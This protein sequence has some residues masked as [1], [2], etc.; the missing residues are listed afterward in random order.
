MHK[1]NS[2]SSDDLFTS[3]VLGVPPGG[4]TGQ[5]HCNVFMNTHVEHDAG[6]RDE[7]DMLAGEPLV[8]DLNILLIEGDLSRLLGVHASEELSYGRLSGSRTANNESGVALREIHRHI[9]KD[10]GGGTGRVC[11]SDIN[12]LEFSLTLGGLDLP[13]FVDPSR[14]GDEM[15]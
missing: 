12:H 13:E 14:E 10:R 7:G 11:E 8:E 2:A 15:S 6:L 4:R 3:D 9:V 1:S 5:S